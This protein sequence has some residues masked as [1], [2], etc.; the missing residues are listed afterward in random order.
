MNKKEAKKTL[1][2]SARAGEIA[3]A[4]DKQKFFASFFQKRSAFFLSHPPPTVVISPGAHRPNPA[5]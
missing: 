4:S 1:L 5:D 2:I 3:L